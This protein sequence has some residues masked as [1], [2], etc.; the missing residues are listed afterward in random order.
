MGSQRVGQDWATEL[1]WA[2]LS[3]HFNPWISYLQ[4]IF[5]L[6]WRTRKHWDD[7]AASPDSAGLGRDWDYSGS[8]SSLGK[9]VLL[10]WGHTLKTK[11]SG[12]PCYWG[13]HSTPGLQAGD[14]V[15]QGRWMKSVEPLRKIHWASAWPRQGWDEFFGVS[16]FGSCSVS[17]IRRASLEIHPDPAPSAWKE[18]LIVCRVFSTG[19][20][21]LIALCWA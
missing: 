10:V 13:G 4:P 5:R 6:L 12:M 3:D 20:P 19:R 8:T 21:G 14:G 18:A 15:D 17:S 1:N 7:W 11:N 2:V 16:E 9:L